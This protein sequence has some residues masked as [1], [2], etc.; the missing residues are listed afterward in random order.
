MSQ[1]AGPRG[2]RSWAWLGRVPAWTWD[3]APA[4]ILGAILALSELHGYQEDEPALLLDLAAV[5]ALLARRRAPRLVF[6]GIGAAAFVSLTF[7]YP[8]YPESCLA[9]LVA[10]Y[11]VDTRCG[12]RWSLAASS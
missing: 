7:H 11:T 2:S 6:A 4:A 3:V 5:V 10:L 12:R 1:S 9:A 8:A